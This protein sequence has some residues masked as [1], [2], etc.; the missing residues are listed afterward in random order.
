MSR[1]RSIVSFL[2]AWNPRTGSRSSIYKNEVPYD[3][4]LRVSKMVKNHIANLF[5]V[6]DEFDGCD[7]SLPINNDEVLQM[8]DPRK[9][10]PGRGTV[11]RYKSVFGYTSGT[12]SYCLETK[13]ESHAIQ[14]MKIGAICTK[15]NGGV[16]L[17]FKEGWCIERC[18]DNNNLL[19]LRIYVKLQLDERK[20]SIRVRRRNDDVD[21]TK[22]IIS[23]K[24]IPTDAVF[25]PALL[26][27]STFM[28]GC[29]QCKDVCFD[30]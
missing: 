15:M 8:L 18:R 25:Y 23:L 12:H 28:E 7:V 14:V 30:Y 21:I 9:N 3:V 16:K 22:T 20:M 27:C 5:V 4:G 29:L 17:F 6:V 26:F 11:V 10:N 2:T 24:H 13:V 19:R 1:K